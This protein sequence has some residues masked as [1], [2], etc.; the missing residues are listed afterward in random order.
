[1]ARTTVDFGID[2]GT[3]NSGI[4]VLNGVATEIVKNNRDQD[5]TPSAVSISKKGELHTGWS[6]KNKLISQPEDVV[7]E[8]KRAMGSDHTYTFRSSGQKRKPEEL[9]AEILKSLAGDVQQRKGELIEAAVVTVPAAFELN[10][11]D[12]TRR[13]A[14]LA[15]LKQNFLLLEPVAAA[16]ACGFQADMQKSYWLVF[17]FGGGT[18]D[19]ALI[20][21]EEGTI[22][23][24]NHGGDNFLGGSDIDWALV[25]KVIAPRMTEEYALEDFTRANSGKGGRW[26]QAFTRLKA[27]AEQAKIDLSR[28]DKVTLDTSYASNIKDE[29]TGEIVIDEVDLEISQSELIRV[30]E[31]F[32]TRAVEITKRVLAEKKLNDSA[33]ERLILVGGPTI[34]PYFREALAAGLRI[35]LDHSVDPLTVVARGAAVF[36]ATQKLSVKMKATPQLGVFQIELKYK[37]VGPESTPIVMGKVRNTGAGFNGW[38]VEFVNPRSQ[39]RSGK[40][41]VREDGFFRT[42][43]HAERGDRNSFLIELRD[44]SGRRQKTEPEEVSYIIGVGIDEQPLIHSIGVALANNEWEKFFEKGQGLPQKATRTLKSIEPLRQ[45]LSGDLLRIPII[46][47]DNELA[48]RNRKVGELPI[49]GEK[50]RRDLPA[51]SDIEVTL[52]IDTRHQITVAVYVPLLDEDFPP[53]TINL[54]RVEP[55]VAFLRE[56]FDAEMR[57]FRETKRQAVGARGETA[58]ALLDDVERSPVLLSVKEELAAAP[59]DH[60]AAAK[61]EKLLLELKLKLDEAANAVEW[62]ALVAEANQFLADLSALVSER[63]NDRQRKRSA[64]LAD[65]LKSAI[66]EKR[67]DRVRRI[68]G[69]IQNV[70]YEILLAQPDFWVGA[71]NH[72]TTQRSQMKDS[73]R[74]DRLFNHGRDCIA[75]N[76]SLGLQ[77][78]VRELWELL[79]RE[80]AEKAKRGY[81]AGVVR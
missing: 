54:G 34:A 62:P 78:V 11:C 74:A 10:Q 12:A 32:I 40:I 68:S 52:E 25:E 33:I 60:V 15:G 53:Y 39:W 67:G 8:F 28:K 4:A 69:N 35:Q 65:E 55:D 23:L 36:A 81:G 21:G 2:L 24:V 19:A 27:A 79:P 29:S 5:I 14:E 17:D 49:T 42:N 50:I 77:N 80:L 18:F 46:E 20:K 37:S 38:T 70:Y 57:R 59:G 73:Q 61:C 6:A 30:A 48:D 9:S 45:G 7:I 51:G 71:F 3:T 75:K 58:A 43:L 1:M 16:L 44:S 76:N 63:G 13:A 31:P 47:G 22:Q 72:V 66:A 64:E 41:S 26:R 56:D